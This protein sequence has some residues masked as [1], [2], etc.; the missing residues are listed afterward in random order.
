MQ[1]IQTPLRLVVFCLADLDQVVDPRPLRVHHESR[2]HSK[3]AAM[4]FCLGPEAEVARWWL[5]VR[6]E[7]EVRGSCGFAVR[8]EERV[9]VQVLIGGRILRES[10][11]FPHKVG[12][13]S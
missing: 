7:A 10:M 8:A 1:L 13:R 5:R 11:D 6:S 3:L 4:R 12:D 9:R 2:V